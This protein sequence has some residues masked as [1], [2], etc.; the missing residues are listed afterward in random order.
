MDL[1]MEQNNIN[2]DEINQFKPFNS[3]KLKFTS[4]IIF[5]IL[6]I[7]I[8]TLLTIFLV[9]ILKDD[10]KSYKIDIQN[11]REINSTKFNKVG[12]YIPKDNNLE[13]YTPLKC[14]ISNCKKCY[15]NSK[16]NTCMDCIYPYMPVYNDNNKIISCQLSDDLP[17]ETTNVKIETT[18]VQTEKIECSHGYY[19]PSDYNKGCKKCSIDFCDICSGALDKDICI[20]CFEGY[21]ANYIR[22]KIKSCD[23]ECETGS[24]EKCF[25][26]DTSINECSSCNDGYYLPSDADIRIKCQKCSVDNCQT[27]SGTIDEDYCNSCYSG[28]FENYEDG[29]IKSCDKKCETGSREKCLTCDT[30]QNICESC[31][32]GYYLPSDATD[33]K[34]C[35]KCSFDNCKSCSGTSKK[36]ICDSCSDGYFENTEDGIIISCDLPCETGNE[37]KCL[38]CDMDHNICETCNNGYFLPNDADNK[39]ICQKCPMPNC[40]KCEGSLDNNICTSCSDGYFA[41]Y[42]DG[43]IKSCDD[44][45]ETGTQEKCLSC[46]TDHNICETC[47]EGYYL[48]NAAT[49]KKVCQACTKTN[50]K[51]CIEQSNNEICIL[52]K[53]GY[54]TNYDNGII[55]S[56]DELCETG[57][58][59]KCLTCNTEQNI[60]ATCNEGYYLPSDATDKNVCQPCTKTNCKT[61]IEQS[62]SEVCTSCKEGFFTNYE[63]GVI[64]SCDD[65]CAIGENEKCLTCNTEYNICNTCNVGYY[66]PSDASDK[67]V[68]QKCTIANCKECVEQSNQET[69]TLCN[70]GYFTNY[71]NGAII[72]SCDEPCETGEGQKCLTCNTVQN[73]C[74][75]CY[76]GYFIPTD[77]NNKKACIGC[78]LAN[79]K[80]C[81][82]TQDSNRC[83]ECKD[84][85]VPV[86]DNEVIRSCIFSCETG[87][88]DKCLTCDSSQTQ[89][90]SCN[91]GFKLNDGK[92]IPEYSVI[93]RYYTSTNNLQIEIMNI[94]YV[95]DV[96]QLIVDGATKTPSEKLTISK[97]GEHLLFFKMV[98]NTGYMT[99]MFR[100]IKNL[101]SITFT[102]LYNS[103][104]VINMDNLFYGCSSLTSVDITSFNLASIISMHD[105]F[106]GCSSLL[107]IDLSNH[108]AP[109]LENMQIF[110]YGCSSLISADFSNFNSPKLTYINSFF[111]GCTKLEKINLNNFVTNSVQHFDLIFFGCSSL[112]S[113]DIS[114]LNTQSAKYMEYMFYGCSGLISLNLINFNTEN[115]LHMNDMFH[116][117]SALTNIDI[118]SFDTKNNIY[119]NGMFNGCSHLQILNINHFNTEKAIRMDYMFA[120]CSSL[121]SI[122][123]SNFNTNNLRDMDCMFIKCSSLQSID[124]SNFNTNNVLYMNNVFQECNSLTSIIING[125]NTE[126]VKQMN[127][128]F[129]KCSSLKE[130]NLSSF[131][132]NNVVYLNN[133]FSGC[134]SLT[135]L[136]ISNFITSNVI[137]MENMF[138][139][140]VLLDSLT[141][142]NFDV[143]SVINMNSMF[144]NCASLKE[145]N[146][147]NFETNNV[148][149]MVNLFSG[150]SSLT[151]I[152]I[153]KFN[154]N[155]V[156]DMDNMFYNCASLKIINFS[157]N[158]NEVKYMNRMFE[159]CTQLSSLNINNFDTSKVLS[160]QYMFSGCSN[161]KYLNI[162]NFGNNIKNVYK[163]FKD[164]DSTVKIV[165]NEVFKNYLVNKG[166]ANSLNLAQE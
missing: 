163:I 13:N 152:D 41:N 137:T 155:K 129:Y 65:L 57:T 118:S 166:E 100:N 123:V 54:F 84:N 127:G 147:Q 83:T 109:N 55:K 124:I 2:K 30:N 44:P 148:I 126:K 101:I 133:M 121:S 91:E 158:T 128:M 3:Y 164:I 16:S 9:V 156:I 24:R 22:G 92:C 20:S 74:E 80:K 47:N 6:G 51:T 143:T 23:E 45:C 58:N 145:L 88:G 76:D 108:E 25:T 81:S 136:D 99:D 37:E 1:N 15:G 160:M 19:L 26:C 64:K 42:E 82:G 46:D 96:T 103:Q 113:L 107:S 49:N 146:L 159:G 105:M 73:I 39:K 153:S 95:K 52:C 70:E 144:Y 33:K 48:P 28:Y 59:E 135:S 131:K 31:N 40:K 4:N 71:D 7:L 34:V 149:Y 112:S 142:T 62:N 154:T 161:M 67:S 11:Y 63:N 56:C 125:L 134:S 130:L 68:C 43:K 111:N 38:T 119:F 29:I 5:I 53:E 102:S 116:G 120:Y 69:C 89:C 72:K 110:L 86:Y 10:K 140:C 32:I 17:K 162:Y 18:S 78:V 8:I 66:L 27:C 106:H 85:T 36:Y 114:T 139:G 60:C 122:N 21:F 93:A 75:S 87:S 94:G 132:T 141:L 14:S 115:V 98:Q 157:F 138:S 117:C 97:K 104:N 12:Y 151:S 50:C 150:C 79:C 35:K 61:C 90:A 77:A 165:V